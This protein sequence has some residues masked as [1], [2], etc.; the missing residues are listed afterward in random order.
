M[1]HHA[2]DEHR[3]GSGCSACADGVLAYPSWRVL[4]LR[5]LFLDVLLSGVAPLVVFV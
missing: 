4:R 2:R 3:D 5:V 1:G